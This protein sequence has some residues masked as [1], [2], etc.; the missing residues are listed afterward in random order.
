VTRNPL[1]T[2]VAIAVLAAILIL[3]LTPGV[4]VAGMIALLVLLAC[5]ATLV[6]D[7]RRRRRRSG[8]SRP[9]RPV[10][11]PQRRPQDR[12]PRTGR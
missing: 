10:P 9:R 6:V 1:L 7:S 8:T 11:G 12:R 4:A 2:D 3:V 5:A